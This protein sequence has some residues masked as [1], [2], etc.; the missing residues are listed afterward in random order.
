[1]KKTYPMLIRTI[2]IFLLCVSML[3]ASSTIFDG[4]IVKIEGDTIWVRSDSPYSSKPILSTQLT[5]ADGTYKLIRM[6]LGQMKSHY[7]DDMKQV[8]KV[9]MRVGT[10]EN[11]AKW[12]F[13]QATVNGAGSRLR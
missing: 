3:Q 13:L 8:L 1:M 5:K 11:Q 12:Y 2:A 6:N 10:F 9:G 7:I 4:L